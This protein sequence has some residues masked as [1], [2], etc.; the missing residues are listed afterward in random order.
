MKGAGESAPGSAGG[1][2]V[3]IEIDAAKA[4][5]CEAHGRD[6]G[7]VDA[8]MLAYEAR[9]AA[10]DIDANG[11]I[12]ANDLAAFFDRWAAGSC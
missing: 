7:D 8:F 4:G 2:F 9:D 1:N 5:A 11:V 6:G 12:D 10:A 3:A